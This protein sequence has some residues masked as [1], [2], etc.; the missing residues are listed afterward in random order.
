M[1]TERVV[2]LV[3]VFVGGVGGGAQEGLVKDFVAARAARSL[4]LADALLEKVLL[5]ARAQ[6]N[7]LGRRG[8][9]VLCDAD[10]Y[11]LLS[12][13]VSLQPSS[14]EPSLLI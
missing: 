10:R 4:H 7:Q 2:A 1:L 5:A 13:S 6:V 8:I 14:L 9:R 12:S 3:I 11:L